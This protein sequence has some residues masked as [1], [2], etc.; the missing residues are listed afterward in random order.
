MEVICKLICTSMSVYNKMIDY[1]VLVY[2][3]G[4][5]FQNSFC[6]YII[7]HVKG[8]VKKEDL[9]MSHYALAGKFA[10]CFVGISIVFF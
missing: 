9:S 6:P 4:F 7:F 3:M 2:G 5:S 10:L 8:M 1:E